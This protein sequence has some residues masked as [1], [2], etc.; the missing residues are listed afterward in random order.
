MCC[1]PRPC[2]G[3]QKA[4]ILFRCVPDGLVPAPK[5]RAETARVVRAGIAWWV[6]GVWP[7][8]QWPHMLPPMPPTVAPLAR[9][10]DKESMMSEIVYKESGKHDIL[11]MSGLSQF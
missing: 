10:T 4:A 2:C 9:G 5:G 11:L 7:I 3:Q 8:M 1:L 6:C